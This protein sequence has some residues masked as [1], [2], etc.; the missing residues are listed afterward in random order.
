MAMKWWSTLAPVAFRNIVAK[1]DGE[2][3]TSA[4]NSATDTWD[5]YAV[6][7]DRKR[8][9]DRVGTNG[10]APKAEQPEHVPG[11]A[12]GGLQV[13][14]DLTSLH[15]SQRLIGQL[16]HPGELDPLPHQAAIAA[17]LPAPT[18]LLGARDMQP[19]NRPWVSRG[20]AVPVRRERRDDDDIARLD[21]EVAVGQRAPSATLRTD[22]DDSFRGTLTPFAI[23]IAGTGK[24]AG[25]SDQQLCQ[26]PL[27]GDAADARPGKYGQALP[28]EAFGLLHLSS[29]MPVVVTSR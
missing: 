12:G 22:D 19:P 29:L 11:A 16:E 28:F 1:C 14:D 15:E 5:L 21:V 20:C 27:A 9:F 10:R 24:P 4:A 7:H 3:F 26:R 13:F 2:R 25:I 6:G 23:M 17:P 18:P 8:P